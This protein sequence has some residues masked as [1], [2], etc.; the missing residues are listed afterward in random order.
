MFNDSLNYWSMYDDTCIDIKRLQ[1]LSVWKRIDTYASIYNN[2][3]LDKCCFC[4]EYISNNKKVIK[5]QN[6]MNYCCF[7]C[8]SDYVRKLQNQS[9]ET[10]NCPYCRFKL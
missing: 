9:L 5:C 6:C 10:L 2:I 8:F 3:N 7:I 1:I 4:L